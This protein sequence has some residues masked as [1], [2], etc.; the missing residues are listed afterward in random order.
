MDSKLDLQPVDE[1][2]LDLEPLDLEPVEPETAEPST[3]GDV[4]S[5]AAQGATF[6]FSD[7][8]MAALEAAKQVATTEKTLKD[9]PGLYRQ[10]QESKQKE[11]AE[12][13]E[14]SPG[15]FMAGELGGAI[16]PSLLTLGA[17]APATAA[18][19]LST[20]AKIGKAAL[21][22]AKVGALAGAG[23]AEAPLLSE[24]GLKETAK[25]AAVGG[26]IGG[27][28]TGLVEGAKKGYRALAAEH[29]PIE[30]LGV[31]AKE[32]FEKRGFTSKSQELVRRAEEETTSEDV[33]KK[34]LGTPDEKGV[35]QGG[36]RQVYGKAIQD[37]LEDASEKGVGIGKEKITQDTLI[38]F[39]EVLEQHPRLLDRFQREKMSEFL[40]KL[41]DGTLSPIEA[42]EARRILKKVVSEA[43]DIPFD[44]KRPFNDLA[45]SLKTELETIPGFKKANE[46]FASLMKNIPESVISKLPEDF[47]TEYFT[48]TARGEEKVAEALAKIV[49]KAGK[50]GEPGFEARGLLEK[51][52]AGIKE[53]FEKAPEKFKAAGINSPEEMYGKLEEVSKISGVRQGLIGE[54]PHSGVLKRI[55]ALLT[56]RGASLRAAQFAGRGARGIQ[57]ITSKVYKLPDAGLTAFADKLSGSSAL[58]PL[59]DELRKSVASGNQR[60]KNAALFAL[61]QRPEAR[62]MMD[63][64]D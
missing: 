57:D 10:L 54:E 16:L 53:E 61:M 12:A 31:A 15:A 6:G 4:L 48:M 44:V 59:A 45:A 14:R 37:S 60:A 19:E 42:N 23:T 32:G 52:K 55:L 40:P 3:F 8:M 7:E 11:I 47:R 33:M 46:E 22:G 20:A 34:L 43:G 5:G 38:D 26:I 39:G 63:S 17:A 56:P 30:E 18:A 41:A 49:K 27:I 13:R 58:K 29:R 24:E 21:S 36:L 2:K 50:P 25:G 28:G 64:E 62:A 1:T 9:L 35:R 51:L